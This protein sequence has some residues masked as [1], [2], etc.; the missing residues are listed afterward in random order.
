MDAAVE[1]RNAIR[2]SLNHDPE[3]QARNRAVV[4]AGK[5]IK[6]YIDK[7]DPSL[8]KLEAEAKAY[9]SK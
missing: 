6:E 5:A 3:F 1:K 4:D 9:E 2:K 8:A 7:A